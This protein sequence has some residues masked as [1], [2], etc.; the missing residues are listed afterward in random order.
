MILDSKKCKHFFCQEMQLDTKT[1][2]QKWERG[3]SGIRSRYRTWNGKLPTLFQ[4]FGL[5]S[6]PNASILPQLIWTISTWNNTFEV[7]LRPKYA[8]LTALHKKQ[9]CAATHERRISRWWECSEAI[10]YLECKTQSYNKEIYC[11]LLYSW[12]GAESGLGKK[13]AQ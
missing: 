13:M 5:I 7:C 3:A 8:R 11:A 9:S 4:K 1:S 2:E 12:H 6:N 10:F